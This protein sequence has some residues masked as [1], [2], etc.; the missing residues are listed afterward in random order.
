MAASFCRKVSGILWDKLEAAARDTGERRVAIAGG[1]S[2]NS[3][4]RERVEQGCQENGW[5]LYM[6]ELPL[7]GDNA[8]MI[9]AQGYYE[10]LAGNTAGMDLNG[11]PYMEIDSGF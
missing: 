6:P 2:A 7:C 3:W 4:L 8:A 9:G 10:L 1:V 5:Q 11:R